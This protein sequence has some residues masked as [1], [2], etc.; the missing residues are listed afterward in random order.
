MEAYNEKRLPL[1]QKTR[2]DRMLVEYFL[3]AGYYNTAIRLAQHSSIEVLVSMSMSTSIVPDFFFLLFFLIV[4]FF[5][6]SKVFL[7]YFKVILG[8]GKLPQSLSFCV[9]VCL[10]NVCL[11]PAI[12]L[13]NQWS[14]SCQ[15]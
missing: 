8:K 1:W 12:Y 4:F 9:C 5:F 6:V 13:K 11:L 3:R 14:D 15:I 10:S 7:I 2:L